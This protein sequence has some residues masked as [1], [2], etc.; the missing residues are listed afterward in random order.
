LIGGGGMHHDL[1]ARC[2][3][4]IARC[5]GNIGGNVDRASSAHPHPIL[6]FIAFKKER[7][8]LDAAMVMHLARV[9][10]GIAKRFMQIRFAPTVSAKAPAP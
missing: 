9:P 1:G 4:L 3:T 2:T 6:Q 5:I 10:S 8:R 7:Y